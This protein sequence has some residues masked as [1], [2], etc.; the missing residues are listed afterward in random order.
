MSVEHNPS[1]LARRLPVLS[2]ALLGFGI[3]S[4]L[5]LY[6][7][8]VVAHVWEPFFGNGSERV[9]HSFTARMLP[10]PDAALGA[11]GY[12]AEILAGAIGGADRWRRHPKLVIAYGAVVAG[13]GLTALSLAAVQALVIQAGCT[14]CLLSAAISFAVAWLARDEVMASMRVMRWRKFE[15]QKRSEL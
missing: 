12:A 8:H 2:L 15:E 6:Q 14:L 3:A 10:V 1:S 5:A 7:L 13:V 9:L 4:Y 11:T